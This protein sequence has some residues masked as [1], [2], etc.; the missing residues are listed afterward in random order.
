MRVAFHFP[1]LTAGGVE[2]NCIILAREMV[3]LG[4]RVEFV[5]N[6]KIGEYLDQIPNG[7]EV[8]D[9]NAKRTLF[10]LLGLRRYIARERPDAVVANMG[11]QNIAAILAKLTSRSPS[12]II[13]VQHNVLGL[14]SRRSGWQHKIIPLFYRF[15]LPFADGIVAVSAG[16]ADDLADVAHLKRDR[17]TVIYNPALPSQIADGPLPPYVAEFLSDDSK[18]IVAVGRLVGEKG[19]DC[20]INA[21]AIA[22]A[23]VPVR[24]VILGVG[25]LLEDLSA[26]AADQGIA[27]RVLLA[28][29]HS[30]PTLFMAR[31]D[32]VV[33]SSRNEGFGNVLVEA[34][35][36]GT[37]V[38]STNCDHG[39]SE[40]LENGRY[41]ALVPVDDA[42]ALAVA[43]LQSFDDRPAPEALKSR[44]RD[45]SAPRVAGYYLNL[46]ENIGK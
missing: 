23:T 40:I 25:P 2:K 34:M 32:T 4:H 5:L 29:F 33:M 7:V 41:G 6:R 17:I 38:V 24:L 35:A 19:F 14:Q 45:F 12:K 42:D 9:L 16:V 13:A 28:G 22:N 31:A 30:E 3:A 36:C 37:P 43:I 26:L 46:I 39:P 8:V 20:L 11:A 21:C 44:A 15:L 18:V 10:S 27:D 1:S